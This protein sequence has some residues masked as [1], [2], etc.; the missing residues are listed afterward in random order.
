M[1]AGRVTLVAG[2]VWVLLPSAVL[3]QLGGAGPRALEGAPRVGARAG[4]STKDSSPSLGLFLRV[5]VPVLP[6]RPAL[7]VAGEAVFH[8]QG[9]VERQGTLDL[10]LGGGLYAGGGPAVLNTIFGD[11]VERETK[12]G[13]NMVVGVR[14]RTGILTTNLEFRWVRVDSRRPAFFIVGLGYPLFGRP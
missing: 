11:A 5:A 10:T 4:W 14:G 8:E 9:L 13:Y 7:A 1:R 3:A 2:V 12:I 6:M